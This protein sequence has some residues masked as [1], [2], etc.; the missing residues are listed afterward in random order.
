MQVRIETPG[1]RD[2]REQSDRYEAAESNCAS[3]GIEAETFTE[4]ILCVATSTLYLIKLFKKSNRSSWPAHSAILW[5]LS[6]PQ[7]L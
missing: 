7:G 2:C 1:G 5:F 3:I 6:V 4:E